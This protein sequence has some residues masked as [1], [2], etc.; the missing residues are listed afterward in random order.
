MPLGALEIDWKLKVGWV[1]KNSGN[2]LFDR[3]WNLQFGQRKAEII[4]FKEGWGPKSLSGLRESFKV[5]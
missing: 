3:H 4:G 5:G 1:L 2:S